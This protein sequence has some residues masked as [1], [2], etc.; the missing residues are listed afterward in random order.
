MSRLVLSLNTTSEEDIAKAEL[1]KQAK[2]ILKWWFNEYGVDTPVKQDD[3]FKALDSHQED[4]QIL[5]VTPKQ[6]ISRILQFY[7]KRLGEEGFITITKTEEPAKAEG[8]EKSTKSKSSGRRK[9]DAPVE[10]SAESQSQ[11]DGVL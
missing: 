2:E 8:D 10:E 4:N 3:F 5:S 7:R 9:K 6:P 1:P 11:S